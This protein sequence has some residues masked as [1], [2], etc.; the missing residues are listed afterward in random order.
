MNDRGYIVVTDYIK[1]NTGEDVSDA[2]QELIFA[3]PHRTI[4]FPDGEYVIAKPILTSATPEN[5]VDLQLSNYATIKAAEGWDSDEAMIRLGAA[6]PSRG[7]FRNG[8][9][10]SLTGGIIDG[11][12]V[13][14]GVSIESGRETRIDRVS[15]KHTSVGLHLKK[16]ANSNSADADIFNV[17][18]I[19]NYKIGSIGLLIES[20]D[21]SFTNMRIGGVQIGVKIVQGASAQI[22]KN[23]HVLYGF[24]GEL[25]SD[26]AFRDSIGFYDLVG[27]MNWYTNCYSDQFATGYYMINGA[28]HTYTDCYCYWYTDRGG[29]Q[30]GFHVDGKFNAVIRNSYVKCKDTATDKAYLVEKQEGGKG[31]IFAPI[32]CVS[33]MTDKT[34]EKYVVG[35]GLDWM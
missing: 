7:T 5:S 14:K 28:R 20:S 24:G 33:N 9:N 23:L 19:G 8:S 16:G 4:F 11:N 35:P 12:G 1:A 32:A 2:L 29:K 25:D 6:E 18:I 26:E 22:M 10:Y 34:H 15:I 31:V 21:N 3:N 17:N 13:A 27:Y 30:H